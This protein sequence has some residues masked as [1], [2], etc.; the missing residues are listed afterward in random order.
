MRQEGGRRRK[1][2]T[3]DFSRLD[4]IVSDDQRTLRHEPKAEVVKRPMARGNIVP[5]MGLEPHSKPANTANP[6]K[7]TE[8]SPIRTHTLPN[9]KASVLTFSAR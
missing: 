9:P 1:R 5:E 6:R 7:H 2:A 8:S 4:L 3:K